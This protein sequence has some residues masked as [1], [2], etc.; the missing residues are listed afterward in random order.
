MG[1]VFCEVPVAGRDARVPSTAAGRDACVP[2]TA[3]GGDAHFPSTRLLGAYAVSEEVIQ[4][5]VER[6]AN[7]LTELKPAD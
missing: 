4:A 3:A 2:S 7:A 5:G 6:I 1:V